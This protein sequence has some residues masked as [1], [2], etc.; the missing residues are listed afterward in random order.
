MLKAGASGYETKEIVPELAEKQPHALLSDRE[1]EVFR[2]L[3]AGG[4]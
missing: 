1:L 3:A 4:A 2:L